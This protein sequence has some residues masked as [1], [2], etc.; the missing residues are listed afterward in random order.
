[1]AQK[2]FFRRENFYSESVRGITSPAVGSRKCVSGGPQHRHTESNLLARAQ[3]VRPDHPSPG[4][5]TRI[6][7]IRAAVRVD[8]NDFGCLNEKV[9]W[10]G[11]DLRHP[12][13]S[14]FQKGWFL[15]KK[16]TAQR[17]RLNGKKTEGGKYGW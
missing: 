3:H 14:R 1:V 12:L 2:L 4:H 17:L 16:S 6:R 15:H 10:S 9:F 11:A 13:Q 8:A 5:R 7:T